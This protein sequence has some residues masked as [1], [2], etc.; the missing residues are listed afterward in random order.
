MLIE[1]YVSYIIVT[2]YY[3]LILTYGRTVMLLKLLL[4]RF[5]NNLYIKQKRKILNIVSIIIIT[6]IYILVYNII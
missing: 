5:D 1:K 6:S 4:F 2:N 3:I